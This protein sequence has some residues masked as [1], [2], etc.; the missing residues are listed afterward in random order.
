MA[1]FFFYLLPQQIPHC[2]SLGHVADA[3]T[4]GHTLHASETSPSKET[5]LFSKCDSHAT[6]CSDPYNRTCARVLVLISLL[7]CTRV[8]PARLGAISRLQGP[9]LLQICF[10]L[11]SHLYIIN[12]INQVEI[13]G[14]D[15]NKLARSADN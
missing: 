13:Y 12:H 3:R 7:P 8:V 4:D 9:P 6:C 15:I 11:S 5:L 1:F 2:R 14:L 10:A